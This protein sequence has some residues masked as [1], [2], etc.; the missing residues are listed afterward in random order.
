MTQNKMVKAVPYH[1]K[2][3]L[4]GSGDIALPMLNLGARLGWMINIMP[5]L[6]YAQ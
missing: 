1:A 2:Q 3:A 4:R 5:Q 6:L